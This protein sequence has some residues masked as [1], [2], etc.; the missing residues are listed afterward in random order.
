MTA[1]A[2]A[3]AWERGARLFR[4]H[5]VAGARDAIAFAQSVGGR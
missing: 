1:L 3:I 5:E 2:C 4:V